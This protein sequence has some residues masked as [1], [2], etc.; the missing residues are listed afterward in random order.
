MRAAQPWRT[1]RAR[2]LR[3][4]ETSAEAQIWQQLRG[5]RFMGLKFVRQLPIGPFFADFACR[6][7][8]I[9]VEVDGGT[10]ATPEQIDSDRERSEYLEREGYRI[11]RVRNVEVYEN[12]DGVLEALWAFLEIEEK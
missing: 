9:I 4:K 2:S 5:R 10:H 11:Y 6:S 12:M 1:N 7:E 3:S 8:K